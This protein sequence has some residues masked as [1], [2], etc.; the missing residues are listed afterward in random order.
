MSIL[1]NGVDLKKVSRDLSTIVNNLAESALSVEKAIEACQN[2]RKIAS[3]LSGA[4]DRGTLYSEIIVTTPHGTEAF[5]VDENHIIRK[6]C[7]D[8]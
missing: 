3:D 5:F 4:F 2:L 6:A 1:M 8:L 7:D